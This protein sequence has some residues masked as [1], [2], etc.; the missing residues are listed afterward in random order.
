MF[1][2][3]NI[4]NYHEA[5]P[6]EARRAIRGL[7][8]VD[9]VPLYRVRGDAYE[10]IENIFGVRNTATDKITMSVS[11]RYKPISHLDGFTQVLDAI[12]HA[13]IGHD[14]MVSLENHNDTAQLYVLFPS[15]MFNEDRDG[16]GMMYGFRF[17]N[18]Y[19]A[20]TAFRGHVFC[21]R[22]LCK[23][24]STHARLGELQVSAM[25]VDSH[26]QSL[27]EKIDEFITG[28]LST[29]TRLDQLIDDAIES[30][31]YF[32][33]Y[34]EVVHTL[35]HYVTGSDRRSKVIAES[36]PLETNRWQMY[37]A[38]TEHASHAPK[39]SWQTRDRLLDAAERN[40][41]MVKTLD[42]IAVPVAR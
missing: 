17:K 11:G 4:Q 28:M 18:Q 39:V 21:W 31:I 20:K 30:P 15:L 36:V 33:N 42:P 27:R 35:T 13:D 1:A 29:A 2:I 38:I 23:N 41:L 16:G 22:V 34:D 5:T 40:V 37:N 6:E 26:I 9:T 25:H 14:M 24:G 8:G 3:G 10:A 7:D 32:N 12:E 19:D